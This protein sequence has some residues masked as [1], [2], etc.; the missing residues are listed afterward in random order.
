M[1]SS[2]RWGSRSRNGSGFNVRV[3][4]TASLR[5]NLATVTLPQPRESTPSR[6]ALHA[7]IAQSDVLDDRRRDHVAL[8]V[9]V[10]G[11]CFLPTLN[12]SPNRTSLRNSLATVGAQSMSSRERNENE[13]QAHRAAQKSCPFAEVVFPFA[14]DRRDLKAALA[15]IEFVWPRSNMGCRG[16]ETN[17]WLMILRLPNDRRQSKQ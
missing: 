14:I 10:R 1:R 2:K 3:I 4:G 9:A 11:C 8:S 16:P 17:R 6:P 5:C 12:R 7:P 13:C 15:I